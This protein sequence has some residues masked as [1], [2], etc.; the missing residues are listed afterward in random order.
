MCAALEACDA[1]G[2]PAQVIAAPALTALRYARPT[3]RVQEYP[4]ET[5]WKSAQEQDIPNEARDMDLLRHDPA[6]VEP[7]GKDHIRIAV[8]NG[9][10]RKASHDLAALRAL[11]KCY[12]NMRHLQV[13]P[14]REG[15]E[16]RPRMD[17]RLAGSIQ[18]D[19]SLAT[20]SRA[21][22]IDVF[23]R[24][25]PVPHGPQRGAYSKAD[26]SHNNQRHPSSVQAG[27]VGAA[28]QYRY[29]DLT[30]PQFAR[31]CA[32]LCRCSDGRCPVAALRTGRPESQ[33][34][35]V[36]P[37]TPT[38]TPPATQPTPESPRPSAD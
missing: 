9:R 34:G 16:R 8:M 2:Q 11:S 24:L 21:S 12:G 25:C 14:R 19:P 30:R 15:H 26:R 28:V 20:S 35:K 5:Q 32:G 23:P 37:T 4:H 18:F 22:A 36:I 31:L 10:G 1:L 7:L 33:P 29:I 13:H 17:D 27:C 3:Q 6:P 38:Q